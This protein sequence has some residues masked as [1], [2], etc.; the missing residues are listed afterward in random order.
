MNSAR[1][2]LARSVGRDAV[3]CT[4]CKIVGSWQSMEFHYSAA[5]RLS[6]SDIDV[7]CP[8]S[9]RGAVAYITL[10]L[11]DHPIRVSRRNV[12]FKGRM[13]VEDSLLLAS[14]HCPDPG[15]TGEFAGN[16]RLAKTLLLWLRAKPSE[17]YGQTAFSLGSRDAKVALRIKLGSEESVPYTLVEEAVS[18]LKQYEWGQ[19]VVAL[20]S[21]TG[22]ERHRALKYLAELAR[23]Q[24]ASVPPELVE[25]V[26]A[27][28][29]AT[30][31]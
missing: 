8:N 3:H 14:F 2:T 1:C 11:L 22:L 15:Y 21:A 27:K 6:M 12:A 26:I 17:T 9:Y 24:V 29:G 13:T 7:F 19:S 20:L 4:E 25:A 18:R 31:W 23:N 30:E 10:P 28:S 5:R 16:Y